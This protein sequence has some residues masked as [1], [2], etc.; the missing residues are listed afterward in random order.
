MEAGAG[1]TP[2]GSPNQALV[3]IVD[4]VWP[5][6]NVAGAALLI[7]GRNLSRATQLSIAGQSTAIVSHDLS[8]PGHEKLVAVV[9]AGVTAGDAAL[10]I[11]DDLGGTSI[12]RPFAVAASLSAG[13]VSGPK[14]P[15]GI[16][17]ET[18]YPPIENFW[19]NE[20]EGSDTY[21]LE[22]DSD[23]Q[24]VADA[25]VPRTFIGHHIA[26][27]PIAGHVDRSTGLFYM[28]VGADS[29]SART[30]VGTYADTQSNRAFRLVLFPENQAGHQLVLFVCDTGADWTTCTDSGGPTPV[31]AP[32]PGDCSQ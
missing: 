30:Y 8:I 28:T 20:C 2:N 9:P 29:G 26:D 18:R 21:L 25:G 22:G 19:H 11:I 3:P 12:S 15:Y 27:E 14:T 31:P 6:T 1:G 10:Q 17:A 5:S 32:A 4:D 24:G 23:S 13:A 7:V 16:G